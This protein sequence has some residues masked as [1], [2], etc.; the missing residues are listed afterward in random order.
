[1]S[2]REV[3]FLIFN[4]EERNFF[5]QH[6]IETEIKTTWKMPIEKPKKGQKILKKCRYPTQ[7]LM[8][9]DKIFCEELGSER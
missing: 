9:I 2:G 7:K 1:M 3:F 8:E 6:S 5:P 4:K